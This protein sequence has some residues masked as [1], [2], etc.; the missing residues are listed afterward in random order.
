MIITSSG[1]IPRA[2]STFE[3]DAITRV[4]E[5]LRCA[6]GRSRVRIQVVLLKCQSQIT[7]TISHVADS[8]RPTSCFVKDGRRKIPSNCGW[9]IY[10]SERPVEL[11]EK[12][13]RSYGGLADDLC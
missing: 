6:T 3:N 5:H 12:V 9:V 4:R 7:Y 2:D 10:L 13:V 8:P 1:L 11:I